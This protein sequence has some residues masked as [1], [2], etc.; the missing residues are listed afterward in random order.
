MCLGVY[1]T[2]SASGA[3]VVGW[4][5]NGRPDQYWGFIWYNQDNG[6]YYLK[7]YHSGQV[8]TVSNEST[9]DGAALVQK[10]RLGLHD[11]QIWVGGWNWV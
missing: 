3:R 5:C 9:A 8:L 11:S 10:P 7:N 2:S 1:N 4:S 6:W